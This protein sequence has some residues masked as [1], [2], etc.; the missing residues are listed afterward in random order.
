MSIQT[1]DPQ[2]TAHARL[3]ALRFNCSVAEAAQHLAKWQAGQGSLLVP[4]PVAMPKG[5]ESGSRGAGFFRER[6]KLVRAEIAKALD[7]NGEAASKLSFTMAGKDAWYL[8]PRPK[9]EV[10][11]ML[12]AVAAQPAKFIELMLMKEL[13]ESAAFEEDTFVRGGFGPSVYLGSASQSSKKYLQL[14]EAEFEVNMK[15][16]LVLCDVKSKRF[17]RKASADS[18]TAA[19]TRLA[20]A[21]EGYLVG[22]T[23]IVPDD[24]FE[25]DAR[26]NPMEGLSLD[27]DKIRR[28][29]LY[30]LNL[31]TEFAAR[32]FVRP[33]FLLH[34][35]PSLRLTM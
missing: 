28:T 24:F 13:I 17:A 18:D 32:L 27:R 3:N 12:A 35:K 21:G 26:K 19:A 10:P 14:A 9:L 5:E 2:V 15:H 25:V 8:G 6:A 22:V 23:R 33:V 29:R 20:S 31:L 34:E 4:I 30:Y 11:S 16:G 7:L 1:L